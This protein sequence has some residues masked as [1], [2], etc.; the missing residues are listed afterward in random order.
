[1][2]LHPWGSAMVY[3]PQVHCIVPGGGIK[4]GE[5]QWQACKKGFFLPVQVLSRWFTLKSPLQAQW[6]CSLT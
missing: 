5:R 6:R 4:N 3:H 1:M 2:V